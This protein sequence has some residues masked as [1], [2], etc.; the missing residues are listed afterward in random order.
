MSGRTEQAKQ[1][2]NSNDFRSR[3]TVMTDDEYNKALEALKREFGIT[4]KTIK[5]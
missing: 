5:Q 2:T 3:F 4:N 1:T